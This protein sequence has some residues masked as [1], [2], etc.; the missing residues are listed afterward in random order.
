VLLFTQYKSSWLAD[1]SNHCLAALLAK[2]SA[3]IQQSHATKRLLP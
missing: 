1:I 3:F 2:I